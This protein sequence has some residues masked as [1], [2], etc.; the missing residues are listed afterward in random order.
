MALG[1]LTVHALFF[2]TPSLNP[3]GGQGGAA[4]DKTD[5]TAKPLIVVEEVKDAKEETISKDWA[6]TDSKTS[7]DTAGR[8]EVSENQS[9]GKTTLVTVTEE[10]SSNAQDLP[11]MAGADRTTKN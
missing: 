5:K 2:F 10:S 7:T 4:K 11:M 6:K 1:T 9:T 8:Q 3:L